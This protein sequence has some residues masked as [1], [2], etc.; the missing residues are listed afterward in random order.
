MAAVNE[1]NVFLSLDGVDVSAYFTGTTGISQTN[2]PQE[3]TAGSGQD[4]E[5][6]NAGLNATSFKAML[7]YEDADATRALYIGKL[8]I[9]SKYLV[10]YGPQDNASG[11]PVHEQSMILEGIEGP[12]VGIKK[13]AVT[14][15]LSFKGADT[16]VRTLDDD[17]FA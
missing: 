4:H 8:A 16:P 9:G 10:I 17:V 5:Q 13:E 12:N 6:H 7:Y 11:K 1:N 3:V 14:F 2:S 15:D